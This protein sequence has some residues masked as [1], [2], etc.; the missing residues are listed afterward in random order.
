MWILPKQLISRYAP[1]TVALTSDS[2]D[3]SQA[4]GQSL[5]VRSKHLQSKIFLREWKKENWMRLRS[6]AISKPFLGNAFEEWWIS[7]LVDTLANHLAQ[8]ES[9]LDQKMNDTCGPISQE[10]FKFCDPSFVSLKMLKGTL[11]TDLEKSLMI[12]NKMVTEQRGEY[13]QRQNAAYPIKD[14]EC[15][16]LPTPCANEDSFRLNGNSQQSKCLEAKSRRG[17]LGNPGPLN[18][19]F[20]ELMMDLPIGWTDCAY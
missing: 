20:V 18:P 13:F 7:S 6:G 16:S 2:D 11:K 3:C 15:S 5:T 8:Q 10:E 12:W 4:C 17:E 1:D 19:Q 14:A 9:N